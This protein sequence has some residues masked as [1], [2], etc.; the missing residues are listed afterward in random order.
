VRGT[1]FPYLPVEILKI[2][3]SS[4]SVIIPTLNRYDLL[5]Q[6]I[7]SVC[8]QSVPGIEI[9]VVDDGSIDGTEERIRS[10]G[11]RIRFVRQKHAGLNAA[12]NSGLKIAKGDFIALLD[13]DDLWLPFKTELQLAVMDR[14]PEVAFTFS[15]FS[16]FDEKGI[17]ASRGLATWNSFPRS[18]KVGPVFNRSAREI[19]LPLV[20]DGSDYEVW[21]GRLYH[22]LLYD[23]YV[24]PS[25]ALVRRTAFEGD[26]PFPVSNIHCGDWQFFAEL[27]RSHFCAF[28][29]LPTTL[30]RSHGDGVRL[31][32][33]SPMIRTRD[34]ISLIDQ[35]WKADAAFMGEHGSEVSRVE[36]EHLKKLALMCLFENRR[37]EAIEWLERWRRLPSGSKDIKRWLFNFAAYFPL[38]PHSLRLLRRIKGWIRS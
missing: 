27:S 21:L 31:T 38:T 12:R 7:E 18:W 37:A 34:R 1:A 4:V 28:M 13:D 23:P 8:N 22:E 26:T 36:A 14:F 29:S 16:I 6:A 35:V 33:K 9:V 19:G 25:T 32:R 11:G 30:N 3:R 5:A 2:M 15:D 20:P 10:F 24:L 17:K